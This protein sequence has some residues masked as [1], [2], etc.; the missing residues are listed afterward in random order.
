M[1]NRVWGAYFSIISV[2]MLSLSIIA[3]SDNLF[4][5]LGQPSN[6][7]PK[8]IVHGLFGLA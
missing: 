6:S 5:D 4:T 8:F 7:D 2:L 1:S 3:F